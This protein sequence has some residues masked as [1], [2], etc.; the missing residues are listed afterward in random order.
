M[1]RPHTTHFDD[2]G[3]LSERLEKRI[4]ELQA[5]V[6]R[7]EWTVTHLINE[8]HLTPHGRQARGRWLAEQYRKEMSRG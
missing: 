1:S 6:A 8:E 7:L 4:A 3:C 5:E 2:C